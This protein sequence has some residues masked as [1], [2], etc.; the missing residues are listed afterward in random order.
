[1]P[2][3]IL[4]KMYEKANRE[5]YAIGQFN[6]SNL[7]F[8]QSAIDAAEEMKSPVIVACSTGAIKYGGLQ[9]LVNLTRTMAE[10]CS[11]PVALHLDHGTKLDDIKMCVDGG[12]TSVMI[13]G[14]H[15]ELPENIRLTR[16]CAEY[17]HKQGITVEAELGRLGGIEDDIKVDEHHACLTD[18]DEAVTFVKESGCD[19]LAVAVG[20]SHGAYKF[21]GDVRIDF[22]RIAVIKKRLGI[23]LVLHGASSVDPE[24]VKQ[25][26]EYGGKLQDTRGLDAESYGRA[27]KNGIN[28]VNIDTDLR[29]KWAAVV[30]KTLHDKPGE[31]DPRNVLGPA[32]AAVKEVIKEKMKLL[33]SAGKA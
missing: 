5:Y 24:S 21:K 16:E 31:F 33:H 2:L 18:P 30:R 14:S 6:F 13:D 15:H 27:I 9:N 7:E 19:S 25:I 11:A 8:L 32:R 1:M 10:K 17:A 4:G 12:F 22:D 3:E 20:T 23:P 26:N 29:L 28:K